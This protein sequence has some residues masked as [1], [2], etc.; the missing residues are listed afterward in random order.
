MPASL[1]VE[2]A[3]VPTDRLK[4][5]DSTP[6]FE[7]IGNEDMNF[8]EAL[9]TKRYLEAINYPHSLLMFEGIHAWPP[10]EVYSQAIFWQLAQLHKKTGFG[11]S[12]ALIRD[13]ENMLR[14]LIK[15]EI[16]SGCLSRLPECDPSGRRDPDCYRDY[17]N[18]AIR[19]LTPFN[20]GFDRIHC[21]LNSK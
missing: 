7:I 13:N 19:S 4:Q 3:F 8:S 10:A 5:T 21:W 20:N 14:S 11:L 2:L 15:Q 17:R 1:L 18:Q 16:D 6:F 12:D 9:D